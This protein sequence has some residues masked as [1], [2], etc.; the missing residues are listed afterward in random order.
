LLIPAFDKTVFLTNAPHTSHVT[1][2]QQP[3]VAFFTPS[4]RA[5]VDQSPKLVLKSGAFFGSLQQSLP[6]ISHWVAL[7]QIE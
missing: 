6:P 1:L 7:W 4:F 2:L 3:D 5:V